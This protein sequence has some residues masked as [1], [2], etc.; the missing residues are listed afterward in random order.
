MT[1]ATSVEP[2]SAGTVVSSSTRSHSSR[3]GWPG[4]ERIEAFLPHSERLDL[5]AEL[6]S[7]TQGLGTFE[8]SFDHLAELTGRA[9][10]EVVARAKAA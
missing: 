9:A 1:R 5:I 4:W 3:E 8:A 7:L 10:D 2:P 6:R